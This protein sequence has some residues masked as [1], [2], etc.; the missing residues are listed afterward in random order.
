[1]FESRRSILIQNVI[2]NNGTI[3]SADPI[4][5]DSF[6]ATTS[7]VGAITREIQE[8]TNT[9]IPLNNTLSNAI[10]TA[11]QAVPRLAPSSAI[12]L[13]FV[14]IRDF[15]DDVTITETITEDVYDI[16][17]AQDSI[18]FNFLSTDNTASNS[19]ITNSLGVF[20]IGNISVDST[21]PSNLIVQVPSIEL[22]DL[23]PLDPSSLDGEALLL[24]TAI[25]L[26]T[27]G[28]ISSS[29]NQSVL[30]NAITT[31]IQTQ[32]GDNSVI[33][34]IEYLGT[35]SSSSVAA[36]PSGGNFN[37][38]FGA[39]SLLIDVTTEAGDSVFWS[40]TGNFTLS[41]ITVVDQVFSGTITTSSNLE[42]YNNVVSATYRAFSEITSYTAS[43]PPVGISDLATALLA[44]I[45]A[46]LDNGV[47]LNNFSLTT[48]LLATLDNS[49]GTS[50]QI[51]QESAVR[52]AIVTS[53]PAGT[54]Y[55]QIY[56]EIV[57][58]VDG[59]I[60]DLSGL[61]LDFS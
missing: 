18:T 47:T 34:S 24:N 4:A 46:A 25:D 20:T 61:V 57:N 15:T 26:L 16:S 28:G 37:L 8:M 39:G 11:I 2:V 32:A 27:N 6:Y 49:A 38:I 44:R 1:M 53:T 9:D 43:Q 13:T 22:N 52:I 30:L 29:T 60:P 51:S 12:E 50:V 56:G 17:F 31:E 23:L 54:I 41:Q 21:D 58:P 14:S 59:T 35:N 36:N 45:E 33:N 3:V 42:P 40:N 5:A 10:V 55:G 19:T 48:P 7:F